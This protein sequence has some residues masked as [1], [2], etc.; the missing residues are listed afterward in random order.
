MQRS[1]RELRS[2]ITALSEHV[3]QRQ[4][5]DLKAEITALAERVETKADA[6][7]VS[8]ELSA[9]YGVVVSSVFV[10]VLNAPFI[11]N[12]YCALGGHDGCGGALIDAQRRLTQQNDMSSRER[13]ICG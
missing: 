7:R 12:N 8:E 2:E 1:A 3:V 11:C 5:R 10:F 4:G 9:K 13:S 6:R